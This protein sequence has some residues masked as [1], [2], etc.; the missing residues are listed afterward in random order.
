M[1]FIVLL[2]DGMADFPVDA[3]GGKTPLEVARTPGMDKAVT[4]G[5]SGLFSPIPDS[6]PAGSDVGNLS[7]F[8]YDP[9]QVFT[10]RAPLEAANQGIRLGSDELAFRCNLVTLDDENMVD[11]TADHITT[12]EATVLI[13]AMNE[14]T[15]GEPIRFSPGVSYRHLAILHAE[16]DQYKAYA[17]LECTPPHDIINKQYTRFLP[18]GELRDP[19]LNY[20]EKS[21]AVFENHPINTARK[22]KGLLPATSIWLWGQGGAPKL[23][24][25]EQRFSK[26]GAVISAVDLVNGIGRCAGLEVLKVPGVTGYL[27][28][29]Y[30]GKVKAAKDALKHHDFVYLHVEAPDEAAHEGKPDL[31]VQAIE[32]FDSRVV[33]PCLEHAVRLGD[34]RILIAPDHITSLAS[35]TH[36]GGPVPFAIHGPGI[37]PNGL[38]AFTENEAA[39]AGL[40][41]PEGHQLLPALLQEQDIAFPPV[42]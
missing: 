32:D 25:F 5:I 42:Q 19:I 35:R 1:K 21:R 22:E 17:A 10:G 16:P 23:S 33:V 40:L 13:S 7:V 11:F 4:E 15:A 38:H 20:M 12:E 28:T 26:T 29:N 14:A 9:L 18:K 8:G 3:L 30:E 24:S 2:G 36:A 31:K 34:C 6:L 41:Y 37:A 39:R 27:D